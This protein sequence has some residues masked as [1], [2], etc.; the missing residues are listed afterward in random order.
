M[1]SAGRGVVLV[2]IAGSFGE[3]HDIGVEVPRLGHP[4]RSVL[5]LLGITP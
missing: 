2:A 3:A 5:V 4:P 1:S